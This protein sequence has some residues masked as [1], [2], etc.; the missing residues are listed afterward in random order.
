MFHLVEFSK[1][2]MKFQIIE[3]LQRTATRRNML[4]RNNL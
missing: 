2:D 3:I 1:R 4:Q